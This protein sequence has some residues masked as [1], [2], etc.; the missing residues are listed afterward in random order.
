MG[1]ELYI[2]YYIQ[3]DRDFKDKEQHKY[4]K[5]D[6]QKDIEKHCKTTHSFEYHYR[7]SNPTSIIWD[8]V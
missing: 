4:E 8:K 1:I 6:Q 2:Y 3:K 5:L 7:H